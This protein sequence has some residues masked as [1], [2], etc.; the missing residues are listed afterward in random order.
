MKR[1][2]PCLVSPAT[3]IN[4]DG[5]QAL[6][7]FTGLRVTSE[8]PTPEYSLTMLT[9]NVVLNA[10]HTVDVRRIIDGAIKLGWESQ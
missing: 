1:F 4:P 3:R 9:V 5:P 2:I 7:P 8:P 6:D 10:Q